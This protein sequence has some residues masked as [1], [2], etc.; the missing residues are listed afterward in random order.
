MHR[1]WLHGILVTIFPGKP[2]LHG[3]VEKATWEQSPAE[4]SPGKVLAFRASAE[5]SSTKSSSL[6]SKETVDTGLTSD[7]FCS[8]DVTYPDRN[9]YRPTSSYCVPPHTHSVNEFRNLHGKNNAPIRPCRAA[10]PTILPVTGQN[11]DT[12]ILSMEPGAL[13]W[14]VG[15]EDQWLRLDGAACLQWEGLST[16][17]C[18][19]MSPGPV[20]LQLI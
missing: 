7:I 12:E 16:E 4:R 8:G 1:I 19:L 6:E 18:P 9:K 14:M 15:C 20:H 2:A 17:Q 11:E 3:Q 13:I 10:E 5:S